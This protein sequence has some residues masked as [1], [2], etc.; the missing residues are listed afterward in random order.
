[1]LKSTIIMA[2]I[3]LFLFIIA[4]VK[5]G[6]LHIEGLKAGSQMLIRTAPLLLIAFVLA[7]LLQVL[8]PQSLIINWLG[9][10][11]GVKGIL[12]S[13]IAGLITPGGPYVAFPLAAAL[14]KSGASLM[15]I[16]TY[17]TAWSV[18]NVSSLSF[19]VAL[20]GPKFTLIRLV[21]MAFIPPLVGLVMYLFG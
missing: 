8:I 18:W 20:I 12:V 14:F 6:N 9:E 7:G 17:I 5:E 21:T 19:E 13:C 16:I 3:A 4:Y 11:A 10:G 15:T 1:M 2:V